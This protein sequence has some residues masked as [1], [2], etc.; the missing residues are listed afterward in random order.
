MVLRLRRRKNVNWRKLIDSIFGS[1]FLS[2]MLFSLSA[3]SGGSGSSDSSEGLGGSQNPDPVL[4]DFPLAYVKRDLLLDDNG[5]LLTSSV[6]MATQFFPGAE[7][8]IR[9]RASPSAPE[10]SLTNG[11]FPDDEDG[12]PAQYDVKDL[13]VA[14]DGSQLAF[15][16]RAPRDPDLDDDEQPRWNLWLYDLET[17][18]VTRIIESDTVAEAGDDIAPAFLP[19]GRIVFSSTR[20]RTAKAVLLDEGKPQFSALDE[21]RDDPALALHVV[22]S[23]GSDLKQITFN[24]SSDFD[25]AVMS[26]GRVV[27]SRWD[28]VAGI[29]RISLY[30]T[31]PD[32]TESQVLYGIHSHD[33]GPN[34]ENIEFVEPSELPDGRL[35]VMMRAAGTQTRMG[36]LPVAI[37]TA[38]YVEHDVPTFEN[39]GLLS[40]AQ[41]I[42]V[43]GDLTLDESRPPLQG[44]Y[45]KIN[46]LNDGTNR[47]VVA[48]S[49][50][51]LRD[52]TS[53]PQEPII[54]PCTTDF[55]AD[56]NNVEADPLYGVWMH[57]LDDETQQPIVVAEAGEVY[58]D[59]V[60]MEDRLSPPV[61]LDKTA[62]IDLDADLVAQNVGV[63]HIRSVYDLDGVATAD[64]AVLSDPAQTAASDRPARFLR[65]I[66]AVSIP[67]DDLVDLDGTAFGRSAAQLM[68]ETIGYAPIQPDGSVQLKIPA[69]IAFQVEVLDSDG[70]RISARHQNWLQLRPGEEMQCVGCHDADSEAP[71]GRIAAQAPSINSGAPTDGSPFPNTE[72]ALFANSGETMAEVLARINGTANPNVDIAYT[73]VWTD[74]NVR[75][76]D[77]DLAY[78]YADLTTP[79]PVDPSC[80]GAWSSLCRITI[81]YE[82]HIHPLWSVDRQEFD[83]GGALVVDNTCTSCHSPVDAA[84]AAMIPT[85]QLDL[86]DG[87]SADEADHFNSYRELLFPDNEQEVINGALIDRLIPVT[88]NQGNPLFEV[89]ENG[90]LVLDAAGDPI[91]L[92]QT[93]GVAPPLRVAGANQ[94]DNFFSNFAAGGTHD[95]RLSAAELKLVSEWIDSGGQYY[96]NPFDVPQ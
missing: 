48:W 37:D 62:G 58:S 10:T 11:I 72:P 70:R 89:D 39:A 94:S 15:A 75:A 25:P 80:V 47:L 49:Q 30:A 83:A 46:A 19:D 61:I 4:V 91:P 26:D 34:D 85:G 35:L 73:D 87:P 20:Q 28:N 7:L 31:N 45:A 40:D 41:E 86:A 52:T 36:A 16:M 43:E 8:L 14:F 84:N 67:D 81:N 66:K 90:D 63:L 21:D 18:S 42:L 23:D 56:A 17:S 9:D 95:G 64:L 12:N 76:K 92:T 77:V 71:H 57:N 29:D 2:I 3:C 79:A 50:C 59:V 96:N 65:V 33:T 88:D 32:G 68:R 82:S 13:A 54:L 69:N 55:L 24:Q 74:A 27:Y 6:R 51:R 1:V 5:D 22:D 78:S 38:N 93:V 53:D 60:V 44:R